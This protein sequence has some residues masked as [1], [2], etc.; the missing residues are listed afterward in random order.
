MRRGRFQGVRQIL[1]FHW[2]LYLWVAV[3]V[4][5]IALLAPRFIWVAA[6]AAF[7]TVTSL[8][9]SHYVYDRSPLFQLGWLRKCMPLAPNAWVQLHAGLDETSAAITAMFPRTHGQVFD[10]FDPAEM[11]ESSIAQAR[12]IARAASGAA[13]WRALPLR[14]ESCDAVFLIFTAHEFRQART[15]A[16]FFREIA[17]TLRSGG[18][19]IVVEHLRDWAN[20]LAFGAGFFHFLPEGAWRIAAAEGGFEVRRRFQVT[21]FVH[22]FAMRRRP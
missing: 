3:T 16:Q 1:T 19:L 6:P 21:P 5:I 2:K 18:E 10:I 17:R 4:A 20:F 22:V 11:T 7:W 13:N 14:A 8:A 12:R 15:R 9:V